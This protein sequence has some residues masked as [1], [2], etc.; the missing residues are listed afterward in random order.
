MKNGVALCM[1]IP[2]QLK[3][4]H[5][6]TS[7]RK[8]QVKNVELEEAMWKSLLECCIRKHLLECYVPNHLV[9]IL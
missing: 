7:Y 6:L 2:L 3:C 9:W 8:Q 4:W 5:F 1:D